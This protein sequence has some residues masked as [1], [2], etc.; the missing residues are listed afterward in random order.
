MFYSVPPPTTIMVIYI[1]KPT[2][3][4][5]TPEYNVWIVG[6]LFR[7]RM[8]AVHILMCNIRL[9]A[10]NVF[11][12]MNPRCWLPINRRPLWHIPRWV[13]LLYVVFLGNFLYWVSGSWVIGC[14]ILF[15]RRFKSRWLM[16]CKVDNYF[17]YGCYR[18][19]LLHLYGQRWSI[20]G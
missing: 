12:R 9:L 5:H 2:P 7:C 16:P 17:D 15:R 13:A 20:Y 19:I 6:W 18:M 14:T 4:Y 8:L 11:R 10:F 1:N 3:C